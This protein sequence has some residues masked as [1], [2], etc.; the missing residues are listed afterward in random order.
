MLFTGAMAYVSAPL[1]LCFLLVSLSLRLLEPHT[2]STGFLSYLQMSPPLQW[3]WGLTLTLL[4]LPRL[5]AVGAVLLR[6]EQ[7]AYGGAAALVKSSILEAVLSA[8][9]AP[10]RMMAHTLFVVTALT[11]LN[12]EWKS[13][14][15]ESQSILWRDALQRFVPIM[16]VVG[17]GLSATFHAHHDA[18]WWL[19]PVGLPLLLAAPLAVFTSESRWGLSLQRRL[20]LLTP[21]ERTTPAVLMRAWA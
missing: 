5:L 7:A 9:Q 12:L 1:W 17:C 6:G 21:E 19:L 11:G 3:L 8:L 4:F 15:R 2:G 18:V 14:K 13:P 20:W 16:I 10:I